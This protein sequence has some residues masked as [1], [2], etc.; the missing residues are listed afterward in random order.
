[1]SSTTAGTSSSGCTSSSTSSCETPP[2]CPAPAPPPH[3]SLAWHD[4]RS[5]VHP[6]WGCLRG[7]P[8]HRA[9]S[10]LCPH[11]FPNPGLCRG[12]GPLTRGEVGR[13]GDTIAQACFLIRWAPDSGETLSRSEVQFHLQGRPASALLLEPFDLPRVSRKPPLTGATFLQLT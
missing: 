9:P 7:S 5:P 8:D 1:M 12:G 6:P 11:S 2:R 10:H 3:P 13:W 4:S